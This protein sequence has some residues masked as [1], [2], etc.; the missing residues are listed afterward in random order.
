[1]INGWEENT[2]V[3]T[4]VPPFSKGRGVR[5]CCGTQQCVWCTVWYLDVPERAELPRCEAERIVYL[6][7]GRESTFGPARVLC[8]AID[9]IA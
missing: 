3:G 7:S 9:V 6:C 1:M 2:Y 4:G 8:G 5:Y